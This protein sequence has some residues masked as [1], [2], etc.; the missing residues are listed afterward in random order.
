MNFDIS[1]EVSEI[2]ELKVKIEALQQELDIIEAQKIASQREAEI[3]YNEIM[4]LETFL[5]KGNAYE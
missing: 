2:V 5:N 3:L 4:Y 1:Y